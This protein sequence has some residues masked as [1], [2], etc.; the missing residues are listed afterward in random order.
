MNKKIQISS[1]KFLIYF[2]P[3]C[4]NLLFG[5]TLQHSHPSLASPAI[6]LIKINIDAITMIQKETEVCHSAKTKISNAR[7]ALKHLHPIFYLPKL[8]DFRD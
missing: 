3:F 4:L 1:L 5:S 8:I 6:E 2:L 7:T